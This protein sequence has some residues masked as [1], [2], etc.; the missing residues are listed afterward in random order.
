[1]SYFLINPYSCF[2]SDSACDFQLCV[3][4]MKVFEHAKTTRCRH[5]N[6]E[7]F[8]IQLWLNIFVKFRIEIPIVCW[9]NCKK[10][11]GDTLLPHPVHIRLL[12][13]C[14]AFP[15]QLQAAEQNEK[16]SRITYNKWKCDYEYGYQYRLSVIRT[17]KSRSFMFTELGINSFWWV[18]CV[19]LAY[20]LV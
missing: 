16:K 17:K 15:I 18:R 14:H 4:H 11:L 1:M 6:S 2:T 3:F 7:Y 9:K 5:C 19:R 12:I 10:I 20:I 13:W 8:K